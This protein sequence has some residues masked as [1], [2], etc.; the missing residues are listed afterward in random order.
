VESSASSK[1]M[2]VSSAVHQVR[3]TSFI[4]GSF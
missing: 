1:N 2:V 3:V 4:D